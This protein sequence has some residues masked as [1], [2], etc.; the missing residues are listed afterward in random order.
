MKMKQILRIMLPV[1]AAGLIYVTSAH[2][3]YVETGDIEPSTDPSTWTVTSA[4]TY[5]GNSSNGTLTVNGGSTVNTGHTYVGENPG[6]TG[7]I[8]V[9]G[10]GSEF[11]TTLGLYVGQN[12]AGITSIN[13]VGIINV[14]N[15]GLFLNNS[16][17][18]LGE[19]SGSVGT[20]N[21]TGVG[22]TF[23]NSGV[24][25]VGGTLGTGTGIINVTQGGTLNASTLDIG[26]SSN[27]SKVLAGATGIVN[28]SGAGSTITSGS[29]FLVGA[30]GAG[31]LTVTNGGSVVTTGTSTQYS[32]LGYNATAT[33]TVIVDGKSSTINVG[34]T[35][36]YL[37]YNAAAA[38]TLSISDGGSV[39]AGTVTINSLSTLTSDVGSTLTVGSGTLTNKGTI[40]LVAGAD[41]A[42]GT[43]TPL[44]YGSLTG[45]GTIQALGGV[46][47]SSTKQVTVN[48]AVTTVAGSSATIDLYT[49]QRG[50]VTNP[51]NGQS[52]GLG[53][54][55]ASTPGTKLVTFTANAVSGSELSSLQ[56]LVGAGNSVLSAWTFAGT[57]GYTTG[58]P[59]YLSLSAGAGQTLASLAI[60]GFNGSS[61]SQLSP[62][63]LAYDGSYA[64]LTA[65]N[66]NDIAVS[67]TTPTPTP[68]PAAVWLLSS[69]LLGLFGIK[70]KTSV[71]C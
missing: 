25:N 5:I 46:W 60:W 68:I 26:D 17:G 2:A 9:D 56:S 33:G 31:F 71:A 37:G 8:N 38:T 18:Y 40:N 41:V 19:V 69:G 23:T 27:A 63:T 34:N 43:Y 52:V 62:A 12:A 47:N 20:V 59:V 22:S 70:K 53:F 24:F 54:Q 16:V 11:Q 66:L 55:A 32:A 15:G 44:S 1:A 67:G 7:T 39:S 29:K 45:S 6:V 48:N 50:I 13:G 64:S 10:A 35:I 61:W 30:S 14:T 28:V 51:T 36:L 21:V 65:A 58:N 42:A 4:N 49:N 3:A 57:T